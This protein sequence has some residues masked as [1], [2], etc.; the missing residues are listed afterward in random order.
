[1]LTRMILHGLLAAVIVA[2][3][4][5]A[6]AAASHQPVALHLEHHS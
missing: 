1:M 3:S 6:Y 5:Y 2:G 4:A